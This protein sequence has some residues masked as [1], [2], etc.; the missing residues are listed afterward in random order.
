[1][2]LSQEVLS[3]KQDLAAGDLRLLS[4]QQSQNGVSGDSLAASGL[5]HQ[6]QDLSFPHGE[7]HAVQR[8]HDPAET[9]EVE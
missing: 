3:F 7:V 1:M 5:T 4:G 8:L 9:A 2:V 6:S